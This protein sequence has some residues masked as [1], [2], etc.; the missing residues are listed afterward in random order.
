MRI[1]HKLP[2][3]AHF[4]S[5]DAE[6]SYLGQDLEEALGEPEKKIAGMTVLEA[7]AEHL[8]DVLSG[9]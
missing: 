3:G 9:Y 1:R 2:I 7:T 8:H 4:H 5:G 6:L